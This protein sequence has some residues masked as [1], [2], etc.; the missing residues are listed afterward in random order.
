[1]AREVLCQFFGGMLGVENLFVADGDDAQF[2][3]ALK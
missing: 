3:S 2:L 1:M